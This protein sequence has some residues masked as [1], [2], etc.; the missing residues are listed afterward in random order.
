MDYPMIDWVEYWSYV[1]YELA[2]VVGAGLIVLEFVVDLITRRMS[3]LRI[4]DSF[5]SLSTQIPYYFTEL[6]AVSLTLGLYYYVWTE[7]A[8]F[9]LPVNA[10]T[11]AFAL[12]GADLAYYWS[13]RLSHE[14]R[15]L[16]V[17]HAVHHSSPIMNTAV[18]FRF[19]PFDPFI[20]PIFHVPLVLIGLDPILVLAAEIVVL[21]YQ[22]WL[23]TELIGKLG[24]L[25]WI[26]N[27]PS[28]HRVH[29][30]SDPKYLDK[31]Y[32]GISILW[33]RLFGTFQREEETPVYGL[34]EPID[35]VNPIKVW[36]SEIPR[37]FRDLMKA[38]SVSEFACYIFA[39]PG[40]KP[41][42]K[43]ETTMSNRGRTSI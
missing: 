31:N 17:A 6:V 20:T 28:H 2:L 32:G 14:I 22:F 7:F 19:S 39:R 34:V 35:S 33:D 9:D 1:T 30:G 3:K 4:L 42:H 41:E 37:L 13:H 26:F 18:A 15:L 27:T 24:P 10:W 12:I 16:W 29:H 25:E 23:H 36:F 38:R 43:A 8:V 21:V 5:A 11:I 40:W